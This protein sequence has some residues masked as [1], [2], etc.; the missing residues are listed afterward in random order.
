M[1]LHAKE[2]KRSAISSCG[3]PKTRRKSLA[4]NLPNFL[5]ANAVIVFI[6]HLQA[7]TMLSFCEETG[8]RQGQKSIRLTN[9]FLRTTGAFPTRRREGPHRFVQKRPQ[10]VVSILKSLRR[11]RLLKTDPRDIFGV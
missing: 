10:T 6:D 2:P 11:W 8:R 5:A 4:R 9:E 3:G 1:V 7:G